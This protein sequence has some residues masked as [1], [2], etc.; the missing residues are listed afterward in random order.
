MRTYNELKS[1]Y[2]IAHESVSDP[3]NYD[4]IVERTQSVYAGVEYRIIKNAPRVSTNE[5]AEI[6][7]R[8]AY[9]FGFRAESSKIIIYVD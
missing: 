7:D 4:I 6:C 8:G 3:D 2:R 5:L 9:N 1:Q